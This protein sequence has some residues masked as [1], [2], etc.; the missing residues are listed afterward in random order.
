[1]TRSKYAIATAEVLLI[2]PA[3][4]FMA[5]LFMRNVQPTQY[6]PAH[7]A[8]QIVTWYAG[9]R[10]LG[11]WGFLIAMPLTVLITGCAT[12]LRRWGNDVALRDAV[13][14]TFTTLQPH[15]ATAVIAAATL[16]AGGMLAI[17]TL[18]VLSD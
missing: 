8:Q 4:L 9:Q 1:M 17:V 5:A 11:L 14:N 3:V 6:E 12:L 15:L 18:H 13:R 7:T 16:A 2:F 10:V